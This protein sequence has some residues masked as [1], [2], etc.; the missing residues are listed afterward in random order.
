MAPLNTTRTLRS[1]P[2]T[3]GTATP[4]ND[5]PSPADII[6]NQQA[7]IDRLSAL[8]AAAQNGDRTRDAGET[9]AWV[10]TLV[11]AM[12]QSSPPPTKTNKFPDPPVLTDGQDPSFEG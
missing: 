3:E 4:A 11:R 1:G 10:E 7:E 12:R 8:L 2:P 5:S 9:P 6:T